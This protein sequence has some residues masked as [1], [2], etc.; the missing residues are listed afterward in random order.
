[1]HD[2]TTNAFE[3]YLSYLRVITQQRS[4]F[5]EPDDVRKLMA[6]CQ[7]TFE[8]NVPDYDIALDAEQNLIAMPHDIDPKRDIMYLSAHADT[9]RAL[10][11]E[12]DPPFHPWNLYEDDSVLVGRGVNDCKAGLAYQLWL[13]QLIAD[14]KLSPHNLIFTVSFKEEG[15]APKSATAIGNAIGNA[16]PLSDQQTYL[17]V[18]EN[19]LTVADPP[20]LSIY[21][22]ERC[23]YTIGVEGTIAELQALFHQLSQWN[24]V[25]IEPLDGVAM[26][27][28]NV[29]TFIGGHVCS[30]PR[31]DNPLTTLILEAN[32]HTLLKAGVRENIAVVPSTLY[33]KE[34]DQVVRHRLVL[35]NRSF[36]T[37]EDVEAQLA[38]ITYTEEKP[39]T[40]SG[41]WK[42]D[43]D[44]HSDRIATICTE[45][46]TPDLAID[47][48]YNVGASDATT[49]R[50]SMEPALRNRILPIVM[51]PGCRSQRTIDPPRLTHGKNETF[52]KVAGRKS[53]QYITRVL[54]AMEVMKSLDKASLH[55]KIWKTRKTK[56]G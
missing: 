9:V 3:Q 49:I 11:E 31:T 15:S 24:P 44:F 20:V 50:R 30:V 36:D 18:L 4:V 51:G 53:I 10:P 21:L 42:R 7:E 45:V 56:I 22:G 34:S 23:N 1:M 47:Y 38:G 43:Q 32:D 52:D 37:L 5:T 6:Y 26:D 40:L 55:P 33:Y 29:T 27:D 16:L 25:S 28:A 2:L 12:W 48:T 46:S 19:T 39:F 17:V 35:S 14:G 41:G 13:S 54:E 8:Q